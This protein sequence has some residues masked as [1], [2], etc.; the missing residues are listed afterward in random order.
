MSDHFDHYTRPPSRDSSVDRYT[1]AASRHSGNS[2]Q[3]SI[4]RSK[5][6]EPMPP[7]QGRS[8]SVF[9]AVTPVSNTGNGSVTGPGVTIPNRVPSTN[10]G[11][12][13]FEDF[14][15]RKRSIGQDIVPSPLG[16]PKRTESLYVVQKKD[17]HNKVS[18]FSILLLGF[19]LSAER[20]LSFKEL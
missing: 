5:P 18:I 13:P 15:I 20:C 9:R 6:P 3:P 11:Q 2:R 10:N 14:I 17:S 7:E 12:A 19:G 8:G 16:H 1:R 4:D